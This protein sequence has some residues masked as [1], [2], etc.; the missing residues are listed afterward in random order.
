MECPRRSVT[1]FNRRRCAMKPENKPADSSTLAQTELSADTLKK[2]ESYL[3]EEEGAMHKH[4]GWLAWLTGGLLLVMSLVHLY[5]A[6][7]IV[8]TL[9]L[10]PL[11][12]GFMFVLAFLLFPLTKSLRNRVTPLDWVLVIASIA[13]IGYVIVGGDDFND[14]NVDPV[15]L[16]LIMGTIFL[17]LILEAARR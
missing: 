8:P 9:L 4:R 3:E 13:V 6:Y 17:C 7:S 14:R 5:A 12:V 11:H 2:I 16:D 10:R 15:R 1:L